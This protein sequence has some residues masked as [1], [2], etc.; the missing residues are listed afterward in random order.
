MAETIIV[1]FG[2]WQTDMQSLYGPDDRTNTLTPVIGDVL[3]CKNGSFEDLCN[4]CLNPNDIGNIEAMLKCCDVKKLGGNADHLLDWFFGDIL[5]HVSENVLPGQV[6]TDRDNL[7][8][9][10]YR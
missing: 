3:A 5:N 1:G 8:V 10:G 7:A 4:G 6:L 2:D 9:I